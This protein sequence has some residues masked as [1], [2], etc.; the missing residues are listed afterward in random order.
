MI[1]DCGEASGGRRGNAYH[2]YNVYPKVE[3]PIKGI[4]RTHWLLPIITHFDGKTVNNFPRVIS[5]QTVLSRH[6]IK[7]ISNV[8]SNLFRLAV[9]KWTIRNVWYISVTY[10]KLKWL[11][12]K[13]VTEKKN[14]VGGEE[15][16]RI[17]SHCSISSN[18]WWHTSL[19]STNAVKMRGRRYCLPS[20]CK[21]LWV[22]QRPHQG[23]QLHIIMPNTSPGMKRE[24]ASPLECARF[25]LNNFP[26]VSQIWKKPG[27]R[28]PALDHRTE[29]DAIPRPK[30]ATKMLLAHHML[31]ILKHRWDGNCQPASKEQRGGTDT[32][33]GDTVRD[34]AEGIR[35][36][37]NQN[38]YKIIRK[39]NKKLKK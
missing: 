10:S 14:R 17:T 5:L 21:Y 33:S 2:P 37:P 4:N 38:K 31:S 27:L 20:Y 29:S 23:S 36:S 1:P 32:T 6:G 12:A 19:T 30:V 11:T 26:S 22:S 34:K 25:H 18:T 35:P 8:L 15:E 3:G 39:Q 9:M 13:Y 16:G 7:T 28:N 24:V